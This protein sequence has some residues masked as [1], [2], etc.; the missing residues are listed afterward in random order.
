M[1]GGKFHTLFFSI[2]KASPRGLDQDLRHEGADK[3]DGAA[4][5]LDWTELGQGALIRWVRWAVRYITDIEITER[6]VM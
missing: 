3:A 2:L 4:E 5:G 6:L 1:E